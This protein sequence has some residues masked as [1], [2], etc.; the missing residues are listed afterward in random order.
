MLFFNKNL[1]YILY[2][3]IFC[4]SGATIYLYIEQ[5]KLHEQLKNTQQSLCTQIE[6]NKS[7]LKILE[8][9]KIEATLN[10]SSLPISS[11]AMETTQ[12]L[13]S[14]S[15]SSNVISYSASS[16]VTGI[17][18][19]CC[20]LSFTYIAFTIPDIPVMDLLLKRNIAQGNQELLNS[21]TTLV[22]EILGS[23]NAS[24]LKT[25]NIL[26]SLNKL[27]TADFQ[28]LNQ[29]LGNATQVLSQELLR[30]DTKVNNMD[31]IIQLLDSK[32]TDIHVQIVTTS[33]ETTLTNL[34]AAS[35]A[36]TGGSS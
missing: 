19:F 15:V 17:L 24:F 14:D 1:S 3:Y 6:L 27:N 33:S 35:S 2:S 18:L 36:L 16:I 31:Q 32:I 8:Q 9:L 28:V 13:V 26:S 23:Q 22:T 10:T 12:N 25:Q 30:L 34:S 5:I 11:S 20:V 29:N 7:Q 4:V 21:Q